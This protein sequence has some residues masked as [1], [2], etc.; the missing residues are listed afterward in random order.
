[1]RY[2]LRVIR[3]LKVILIQGKITAP[4]KY[5]TG[6]L[7]NLV[8]DE[9]EVFIAG[10]GQVYK[11]AFPYA[12]RIYITVIDRIID[13]N[14]YFPEICQDDFIKIYEEL[15]DGEIPYTYYTYERRK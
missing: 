1:V 11:D 2:F 4:V 7:E 5:L 9:N 14:I 8:N 6:I 3:L 10:G 13:G 15:I 12:D